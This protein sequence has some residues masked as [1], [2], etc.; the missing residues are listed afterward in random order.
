MLF[1]YYRILLQIVVIY[2][3]EKDQHMVIQGLLK[4]GF[5]PSVNIILFIPEQTLDE[6]FYVMK[7]ATEYMLQGTQIAMTPLLRPQ[8]GSG[9][10][11][12][13]EKGLTPIKAKYS[14]WID[15]ETKEVF[16]Y[17]IYCITLEKKLADFIQQFQIEEYAFWMKSE[18]R[19]VW[20][21]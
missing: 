4:H 8:K 16:K 18:L 13:I 9:I 20:V 12:L 1:L 3:S 21:S 10:N 14:E 5:S 19:L 17:P 11:E 2:V 7:T 6:L 15:P